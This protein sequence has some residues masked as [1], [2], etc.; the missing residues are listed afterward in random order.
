MTRNWTETEVWQERLKTCKQYC[1]T[2]VLSNVAFLHILCFIR[3]PNCNPNRV[4]LKAENIE[5]A[6][7]ATLDKIAGSNGRHDSSN[8]CLCDR[9]T[10]MIQNHWSQDA[11]YYA[12][13]AA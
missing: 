7:K 6:K 10:T 3:N 9:Q 12:F 8:T 1:S 5:Y 11:R 13:D 2:A 4:N